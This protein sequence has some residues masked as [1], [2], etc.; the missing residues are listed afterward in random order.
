MHMIKGLLSGAFLALL[1]SALL[2]GCALTVRSDVNTAAFRP[3]QCRTFAFNGTFRTDNPM[4]GTVANP[5]N[6]SR[7]R[8]AITT[9]MQAMGMQLAAANAD[10]LVGYG[11]GSNLVVD[12]GYPYGYGYWGWGGP[13]WGAGP[14][15]GGGYGPYVYHQGVIGIDLFD[16][17]THEPLWHASVDQNLYNA[18]GVDAE[19]RINVAVDALFAHFPT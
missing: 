9:H 4:R 7:L 11:I 13:Y 12:P 6:E 8:A 1:A 18:A 15:W 17:K 19:Q 10:C 5:V 2:A 14:Y 3:G 16:G